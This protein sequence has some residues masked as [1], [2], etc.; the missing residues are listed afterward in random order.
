MKILLV[1]NTDWY[2]FNFRLSL[3]S[4]LRAAGAEVI[5]VSP[6]GRFVSD[7]VED[8]FRWLEW[9]VGRKT[10]EPLR[11]L[12]SVRR[13][14][15]IY[16]LEKPDL[17]HHFT[18]KPVLYGSLA[19]R[20]ANVPALVNSVTGLGYVFL[21]QNKQ[22][23]ALRKV[24]LPLYRLAFGHANL[25]VIFENAS[26]RDQFI[27]MGLIPE[28]KTVV[29]QGVGVD[30]ERFTPGPEPQGIPVVLFP[31]RMLLDKGLGT[32]IEA[33]GILKQNHQVRVVLVGEPDP[34]N[35]A[36][37][38]PEELHAWQD[39]GL[40]EWWG[41][42]GGMEN[43]Y[44]QATVVTLP[45][46][47]EGLPTALI[48]AAACGRAIVATD[49]PGC[50]EVVE[51]GINGLLVPPNDAVALA[52][53][54]GKVLDDPVLRTRMGAAGRERV[55]SQ[56]ADRLI[57]RQILDIYEHLLPAEHELLLVAKP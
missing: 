23:S 48:E 38:E 43:I 31:A 36:T 32:L 56:F 55:L 28:E 41:F 6:N 10:T 34:G 4:R 8:G 16:Q 2:L 22:G 46:L 15:A 52:Q 50:R 1:A 30:I 35:P 42:Q 19:A 11:E 25:A 49:V 57:I 14:A 37:V 3:A 9:N 39:A 26:D 33:T 45:S 44:P 40:V 54:L 13:L 47:G 21:N 7:I 24:V 51:N 12:S 53:A 20:N 18:I 5:L 17:V 29:V 27:Q